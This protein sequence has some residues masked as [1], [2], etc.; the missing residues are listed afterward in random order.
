MITAKCLSGRLV[1]LSEMIE[2]FC[3]VVMIPLPFSRD[4][5]SW[6][7]F[8]FN[9]PDDALHLLELLYGVLKL[10]VQIS[11]IGYHHDGIE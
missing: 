9:G 10:L 1:I 11:A 4:S 6:A 2:N 8:F 5:F 7:E 3:R